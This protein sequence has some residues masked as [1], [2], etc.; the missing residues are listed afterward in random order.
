M[1]IYQRKIS[2]YVLR[3]SCSVFLNGLAFRIISKQTIY[4]KITV[5]NNSLFECR[6][7]NI[8]I[9]YFSVL[10]PLHASAKLAIAR[11]ADKQN[12][13][14]P[15]LQSEVFFPEVN[16]NITRNQVRTFDESCKLFTSY[17]ALVLRHT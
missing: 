17:F 14:Q 12:F 13:Q 9:V 2:S 11:K 3:I 10:Q 8:R 7:K 4:S 5:N 6:G 15:V 16:L 1:A